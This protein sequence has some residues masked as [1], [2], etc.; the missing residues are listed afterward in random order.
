M[1][2]QKYIIFINVVHT[3]YVFLINSSAD[4]HLGYFLCFAIMNSTAIWE[5]KC[6]FDRLIPLPLDACLVGGLLDHMVGFFFLI[7][8][9]KFS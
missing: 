7:F 9:G 1:L 8:G 6:H 3:H 4:G 5:Y 2:V